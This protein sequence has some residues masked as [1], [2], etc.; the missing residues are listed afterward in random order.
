[1]ATARGQTALIKD[2]YEPWDMTPKE[3]EIANKYLRFITYHLHR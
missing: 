1:L 3:R 2:P